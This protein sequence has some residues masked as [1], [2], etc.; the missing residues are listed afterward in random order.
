VIVETV[1]V[2]QSETAVAGMTDLFVLLQLPNAGD[3]LQA[4][5][6][7]IVELADVVVV[8]KA[9]LDPAAAE[10]AYRQLRRDGRT[11][12]MPLVLDLA[13]PSPGGGWRGMERRSI[14]E[15]A[16]ADGVLALAL[17]HHL[18]I[19]RNVPLPMVLDLFADLAP[20]VIVEFVPK[21]DPMVGQLLAAREDIFGD[22]SLDGFRSAAA[23]RFDILA[24][25][26]I[27]DSPRILFHLRRR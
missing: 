6:K 24:E 15:R 1:G 8:T 26:P 9:D 11:D 17:V 16:G 23:Q 13:D 2:G 12:I 19:G 18:A 7:G 3:D 5:K 22:Y 4:M 27:A 10:R 25:E 21:S 14:L 20:H